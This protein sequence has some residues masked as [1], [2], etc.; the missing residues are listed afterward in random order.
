[1]RVLVLGANGF[2]GSAVAAALTEAGTTVRAG[3]RDVGTFAR[4]FPAMEAVSVDLRDTAAHD[5]AYWQP[6]LQDVDAVVN[7]AG[8]LQPRREAD[9]WAVHL[10]APKALFAAC[11]RHGVRRVVHVSAIGVAEAETVYARSKRAGDG[12]AMDSGLDWT[13]LR[14]TVVFG[15]GSYG[16]TSMLRAV[17]AIP[18]VTPLIGDGDTPMDFIHKDDLAA[19]IVSLLTTGGGSGS[20]LEPAGAER[21]TFRQAVLAYRR[22][23]GLTER[24]T[25]GVPLPLARA[26]A[27][28]GDIVRLDPMTTTGIAQFE[29]RL[30]GDAAGFAAVTGI[31]PRG[32][33]AVLAARPSESQDLWHARLYLLRP[34]IRLA[35]ALLWLVSGC[36][37]L[38]TDPA[39][40]S[41]LLLPDAADA[42]IARVAGVVMGTVD[43]AIAAALVFGWRLRTMAAVQFV[44]VLGYT[45]G[46]TALAPSLWTDPF[47]ALLKNVPIL[48]LI[49]VHRVL[50]QER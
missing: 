50:E 10:H 8:V 17:A 43:L 28:I 3:V 24:R 35:L 45:V 44:L 42:A 48:A 23:L 11:A 41:H 39:H 27:R 34:L 4:R 36:L 49:A 46:L 33:P 1:M 31:R 12:A 14:P 32:L 13:I 26:L 47:G 19:G 18:W 2:I 40:Y 22:W 21:L 7:V 38:L 29:T 15:D 30:T 25:V 5:P 20:V 9:A 6:A 37:G 16:G